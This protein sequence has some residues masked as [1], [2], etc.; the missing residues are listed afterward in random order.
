[1]NQNIENWNKIGLIHQSMY[2]YEAEGK[3]KRDAETENKTNYRR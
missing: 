3:R 1:M 2:M